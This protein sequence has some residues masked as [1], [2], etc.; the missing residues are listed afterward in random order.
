M[1]SRL[2][3]GL[4]WL[5]G[6]LSRLILTPLARSWEKTRA[7]LPLLTPSRH[8][9]FM[10]YL[11]LL[12][13]LFVFTLTW[14][15]R[16]AVL[17]RS[18]QLLSWQ[19][20]AF[21]G[22]HVTFDAISLD[23]MNLGFE[24]RGLT[25]QSDGL[26]PSGPYLT[27]DV[28]SAH[29]VSLPN[30]QLI[31][32]GDVRVVR[33][34]IRV[35]LKKGRLV[36]FP[37]I[38][39]LIDA[40]PAPEP[41]PPVQ[42][43]P[44]P[45]LRIDQ[46]VIQDAR[47]AVADEDAGWSVWMTGLEVDVRDFVTPESPSAG[48]STPPAGVPLAGAS[49][50]GA[51]PA[52]APSQAPGI[53]R[54][55]A[56]MVSIQQAG[57]Q[58]GPLQ[59]QVEGL[60]LRADLST[61][62]AEISELFLKVPGAEVRVGGSVYLG[63]PP[64]ET[65]R[66]Q[67]T[68]HGDVDLSMLK[69]YLP[70][71][72]P[73]LYGDVQLD[74]EAELGEPLL[75]RG[76]LNITD[77]VVNPFDDDPNGGF[78]VGDGT[79]E[80][81]VT[82]DKITLVDGR[83]NTGGGLLA[84]AGEL[85]LSEQLP[86]SIKGSLKDVGLG[87]LLEAVTLK[88]PWMNSRLNGTVEAE[89]TLMHPFLLDA[90]AALEGTD[91]RL[92]T[93]SF[94]EATAQDLVLGLPRLS[95]SSEV[96]IDDKAATLR[97][98]LL[99]TTGNRIFLD[100]AI[101]FDLTLDLSFDAVALD[102]K[103]LS[104][105]SG[106]ALLGS[107][108]GSGQ[109]TGP[110]SDLVVNSKL[111]LF[112]AKFDA[113]AL[114]DLHSHFLAPLNSARFL[115]RVSR[116]IAS[117]PS[118]ETPP[119]DSAA[120]GVPTTAPSPSRVPVGT[121]VPGL[122]Q[123]MPLLDEANLTCF[124]G[125]LK[126]DSPAM[127]LM[128]DFSS[129]MGST[130][131]EGPVAVI[132]SNPY[133]LLAEL[134][135]DPTRTPGSSPAGQLT[136][137]LDIPGWGIDGNPLHGRVRGQV[138]VVGA[139]ARLN[140]EASLSMIDGEA[141]GQPIPRAEA[142][143]HLKEGVLELAP[144]QLALAGKPK[145]PT[146]GKGLPPPPTGGESAVAEAVTMPVV[147]TGTLTP[148]SV[149][150]AVLELTGVDLPTLHG[151]EDANVTGQL[152]SLL[153]LGGTLDE[154]TVDG[155]L[156]LVNSAWE[157]AALGRSFL[158][159][160]TVGRTLQTRGMLL[161]PHVVMS[162]D[163]QLTSDLPFTLKA[164]LESLDLD[165]YLFPVRP[166]EQPVTRLKL[167]GALKASGALAGDTPLTLDMT[168]RDVQFSH[169][170]LDLTMPGA[171]FITLRNHQV[172]IPGSRLEG[173]DS[174]LS[175]QGTIDLEKQVD[176]KL[177]GSLNLGLMDALTPGTFQR[178]E[179][180]LQ[181]GDQNRRSGEAFKIG[182]T[183]ESLRFDGTLQLKDAVIRT[184][185]FPPTIDRLNGTFR[186][187]DDE[188]RIETLTGYLGGGPLDGRGEMLLGPSY[189]PIHY[190]LELHGRDAFLRYPSFL[191]PGVSDLDLKFAGDLDNLLLSGDINLK[192]M[193]YRERYNWE[194]SLTDFRTYQ[195]ENLE[196]GAD[197]EDDPLFNID[198][199]IHVPG[200]FYVR[201]N[202]GNIQMKAELNLTGDT[203][204]MALF[205]DVD[206]VR[207]T[208]SM[209]DNTFELVQG[210]IEFTGDYYNPRL[211]LKMQTQIQSY[212]VYYLIVGDL[213]DWQLIPGSD[214][215]LS[216]RD[217]NSLIAFRTLADNITEANDARSVAAPAL[218]FLIGRLGLLDQL[219]SF[220]MLDRFIITPAT[221]STGSLAARVYGEKELVQNKLFASGYYDLSFTGNQDFQADV[222]WRALDCCSLI[223]RFDNNQSLGAFSVS[224]GV[225]LKLKLEFE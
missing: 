101:G 195:L 134:R 79:L 209:L 188:V 65:A 75:V 154:P 34:R 191:P 130:L 220:T 147:L 207:G 109:I 170:G 142:T 99:E 37:G 77:V 93:R 82:P 146:G 22:E 87:G 80:A 94:H 151:L 4:A 197:A 118:V 108:W 140:G 48:A 163:L 166:G 115:E 36:H 66:A 35:A 187:E 196:V 17:E 162:S 78:V 63:E 71:G 190:E 161:S 33:P 55:G 30:E 5:R 167:N 221:D 132:F 180:Q 45:R 157:G 83:L 204:N 218:E 189:Y 84:L 144:L 211:N 129:K 100:G 102:M 114:G 193:V 27:I 181:V 29:L 28:I 179:G 120:L 47:I 40:P 14:I 126:A 106:F 116:V 135:I 119:A 214:A 159:L 88:N 50:V 26:D 145:L 98:G 41:E 125:G 158:T 219:Q 60:S 16:R 15:E 61:E 143:I 54:P 224:P 138:R 123:L 156:E 11:L 9:R 201:N 58:V 127:L 165:P 86:L 12:L 176:L 85:G 152:R 69:R 13:F 213:N 175:V 3:R 23:V 111:D 148:D 42:K 186:L 20:S 91:Y 1:L 104:P 21:L 225:R 97:G 59:D 217:I 32:V 155:Q 46:L 49:P 74:A 19:L 52:G 202:I 73:A 121:N 39:A 216:E 53:P 38:Q 169:K 51:S 57:F 192:R 70:E 43:G 67:A 184:V 173:Q 128:P 160:N 178:I 90:Q 182:G 139:P 212:S 133:P 136:D 105:L 113:Y 2:S 110:L 153:H 131:I 205:G 31:H 25:V 223:L 62:P 141:W 8:P 76:K 183:L 172:I 177:I 68:A 203:N 112:G 7:R 199:R 150:D 56:V 194:E 208:V 117:Q 92:Y 103:N 107:G 122:A 64:P 174:T 72:V 24:A 6:L 200:T 164:E 96:R 149:V 10:R 171:Q 89:G 185:A 81:E 137:L 198:I 215:G 210:H 95:V 18:V 168:T 124:N 222:E 206:S 44:S